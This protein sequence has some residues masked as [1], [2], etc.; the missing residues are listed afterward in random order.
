MIVMPDADIDQAVEGA[1]RGRFYNAG[2]TCTA[3]KRLYVHEKIAAE[4]HIKKLQE[5]VEALTVGN[6][7]GSRI[8]I[9]PMN[10]AEQ[11][12]KISQYN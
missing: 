11:R 6:G 1:L 12:E 8:D 4:C 10:S 5:R 2:Q 7:L 9:G 3:V